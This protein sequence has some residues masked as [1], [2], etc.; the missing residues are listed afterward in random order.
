MEVVSREGS[1]TTQDHQLVSPQAE[2]VTVARLR[3]SHH[4]GQSDTVIQPL[5]L[6]RNMAETSDLPVEAAPLGRREFE[7]QH[8][9]VHEVG[10]ATG[11]AHSE[12]LALVVRD[13]SLVRGD[14][15]VSC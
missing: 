4:S 15:S 3:L 8:V 12:E 10:E 6:D 13:D 9:N 5:V 1:A 2:L 14:V 7:V 11:P